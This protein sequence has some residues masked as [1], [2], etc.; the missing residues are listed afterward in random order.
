MAKDVVGFGTHYRYLKGAGLRLILTSPLF[1]RHYARV[2][3]QQVHRQ[4]ES[5]ETRSQKLLLGDKPMPLLR[6]STQTQHFS[7]ISL[8]RDNMFWFLCCSDDPLAIGGN[9]EVIFPGS[10]EIYPQ[11]ITFNHAFSTEIN[12]KGPSLCGALAVFTSECAKN[13]LQ[14]IKD[15]T[16]I[17]VCGT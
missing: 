17:I 1:T 11:N 4:E 5:T 7:S 14:L 6:R 16:E 13:F 2:V 10:D 3:P 8:G 9:T 12:K 15:N